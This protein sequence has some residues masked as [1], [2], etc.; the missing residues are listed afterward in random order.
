MIKKVIT[1]G[2]KDWHRWLPFLL[3]A[4][5]EV[6][7]ASLRFSPFELLYGCHP[8]GILDV[9]REEW[10]MTAQAI[11]INPDAYV[12]ALR[13][14][15]KQVAELAQRSWLRSKKDRNGAMTPN[16]NHMNFK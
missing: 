15:F 13:A 12:M 7:Q 8:R 14:K 4:V 2:T 16:C 5:M 9:V 3:F 10:E 6:P 11:P 1:N